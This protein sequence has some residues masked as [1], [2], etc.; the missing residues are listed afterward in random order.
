MGLVKRAN[1]L[2]RNY[3]R[4]RPLIAHFAVTYRCN[5]RCASCEY[6]RREGGDE[7]SLDEI[8]ILADELWNFGI[9]FIIL[10]GGEPFMREDFIKIIPL[11]LEGGYG[12]FIDINGSL[13]NEGIIA[14]LS[15]LQKMH[16]IVSLDSLDEE[17]F[18][19]IRGI[20][21]LDITLAALS[22]LKRAGKHTV[23]VLSTVS[24]LNMHE[25]P[26][27]VEFCRTNGILFSCYPV[28]SSP[29]GRWY[30]HHSMRGSEQDIEQCA[31]LFDW[32][33]KSCPYNPI[34]FGFST[35]YRGAAQHLR[36]I[37][38][39]ECGAGKV[40]LHIS[41]AGAVSACPESQPFCNILEH[42][43][44]EYY[45]QKGWKQ[46]V[47]TCYSEQPCY[48]GSSR[49]PLCISRAPLRFVLESATKKVCKH[50]PR[51]FQREQ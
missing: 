45:Q 31:K 51:L 11:F 27:I 13:L 26:R 21:A 19:K 1:G 15:E 29:K 35:I 47:R 12:V 22:G 2:L 32:L 5:S 24:A 6:H 20:H 25:I 40:V 34:L 17:N 39:G 10:S 16:F 37:S 30:A 49:A 50:L 3:I 44:E 9:R 43:L 8:K 41:P 23:R 46:D 14:R 4:G 48:V 38:K 36:G 42:S 7:L 28:M 18:Y 33:A